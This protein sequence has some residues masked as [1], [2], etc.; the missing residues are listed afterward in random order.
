MNEMDEGRYAQNFGEDL[1]I[2]ESDMN[3]GEGDI[4]DS[5]VDPNIGVINEGGTSES[6]W[7]K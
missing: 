2:Q 5:C 1:D 3:L 4:N 6:D 7:N